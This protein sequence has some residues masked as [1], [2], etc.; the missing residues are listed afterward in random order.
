MGRIVSSLL[1]VVFFVPMHAFTHVTPTSC[2]ASPTQDLLPEVIAPMTGASP[3]WLVDGGDGDRFGW[4][5]DEAR[6]TLWVLLRT[7]QEMRISGRRLDA[8]GVLTLTIDGVDSRPTDMVVIPD[9][10]RRSVIPGG[11]SPEIMR[12][13]AFIPSLVFYPSPGCWEFTIHLGDAEYRIVR[14][15]KPRRVARPF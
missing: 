2:Q 1:L 11:A 10:G 12:T 14:D 3:V 9:P 13:Y 4:V 6:K 8:P 7:S 15:L 5:R